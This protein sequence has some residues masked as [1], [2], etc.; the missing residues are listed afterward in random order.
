M[1]TGE[2]GAAGSFLSGVPGSCCRGLLKALNDLISFH[3]HM[4][5][6]LGLITP[7]KGSCSYKNQT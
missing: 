2:P 4:K 6:A 3:F 5:S 7:E 1:Q